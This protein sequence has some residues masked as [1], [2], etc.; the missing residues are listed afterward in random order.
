[1]SKKQ[2]VSL[3]SFCAEKGL[4][5]KKVWGLVA[6]GYTPFVQESQ[7]KPW[8]ALRS[9]AETWFEEHRARSA[10]VRESA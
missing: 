3:P 9:D 2:I 7:H 5:Y 1:M 10:A 8:V 6:M 4:D